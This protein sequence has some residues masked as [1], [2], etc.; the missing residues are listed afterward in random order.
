MAKVLSE[1]TIGIGGN[2]RSLPVSPT[3]GENR[4]LH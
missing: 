4:I 2:G 3:K 1:W